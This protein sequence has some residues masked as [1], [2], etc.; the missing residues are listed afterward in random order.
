MFKMINKKQIIMS[1]RM[2]YKFFPINP[3][4]NRKKGMHVRIEPSGC[5]VR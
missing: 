5:H 2:K 4:N 1:I 3:G